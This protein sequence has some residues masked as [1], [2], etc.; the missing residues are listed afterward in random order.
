MP[1]HAYSQ[2][3][4]IHYV[5]IAILYI[6]EVSMQEYVTGLAIC[7]SVYLHAD[8]PLYGLQDCNINITIVNRIRGHLLVTVM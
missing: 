7:H 1:S 3:Y 5:V 2:P 4:F 6:V 8:R